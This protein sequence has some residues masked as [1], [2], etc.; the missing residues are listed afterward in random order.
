MVAV[1]AVVD[2][3]QALET[4]GEPFPHGLGADM[5]AAPGIGS[6]RHFQHGIVGED[7]HDAV[8]VVVVE[9]LTQILQGG[10]TGAHI[11]FSLSR[12]PRTEAIPSAP[13]A[14]PAP[15]RD[16]HRGCA[17]RAW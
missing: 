1:V 9:R 13:S 11:T 12:S 15:R 3:G 2:V 4:G 5:A 7:A 17:G 8:E 10:D 6:A 16:R 14:A